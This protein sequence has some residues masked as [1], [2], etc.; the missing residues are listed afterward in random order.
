MLQIGGSWQVSS[1]IVDSPLG[2]SVLNHYRRTYYVPLGL[3]LQGV[4]GVYIWGE[5]YDWLAPHRSRC[6]EPEAKRGQEI[7]PQG[8]GL[9]TSA[10]NRCRQ[11]SDCQLLAGG[12]VPAV[13]AV[14]VIHCRLGDQHDACSPGPQPPRT[15]CIWI[16]RGWHEQ[17]IAA[18]QGH[19]CTSK[20]FLPDCPWCH[21]LYSWQASAQLPVAARHDAP[22]QPTSRSVMRCVPLLQ[23]DELL[24]KDVHGDDGDDCGDGDRCVYWLV[25]HPRVSVLP[26]T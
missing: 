19:T 22:W 1:E 16:K 18:I 3:G 12:G 6:Q 21:Y 8:S 9:S 5:P 24:W 4:V 23:G 20:T 26:H 2:P 17:H 14:R 15:N 11:G 7:L 10:G 25:V 13:M